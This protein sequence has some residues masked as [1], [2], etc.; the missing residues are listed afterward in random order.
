MLFVTKGSF[1]NTYSL[2]KR[3]LF[4]SVGLKHLLFNKSIID[5]GI[6]NYEIT[7]IVKKINYICPSN[8]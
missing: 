3:N 2:I 5:W 8:H 6:Y 7:K 1:Y 4:F